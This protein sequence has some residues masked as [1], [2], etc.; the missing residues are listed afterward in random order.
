[1]SEVQILSPRPMFF[2]NY[3]I[4]GPI[5]LFVFAFLFFSLT[6]VLGCSLNYSTVEDTESGPATLYRISKGEAL[7]LAHDAL[8]EMF[9]G[10]DI[11]DIKGPPSG[12]STSYRMMLDT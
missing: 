11:T 10:R 1:M 9:P 8:A 12:Y 2:N 4:C 6:T 3:P 5:S 7:Q